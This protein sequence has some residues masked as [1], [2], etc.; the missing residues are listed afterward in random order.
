MTFIWYYLLGLHIKTVNFYK[1]IYDAFLIIGFY[2]SDY[3]FQM[4]KSPDD[5]FPDQNQPEILG[6]GK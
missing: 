2:I 6:K 1:L 4:L 3:E 5:L